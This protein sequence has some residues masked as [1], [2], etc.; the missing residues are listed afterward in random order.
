MTLDEQ[1]NQAPARARELRATAEAAFLTALQT[2]LAVVR[3]MCNLARHEDG[4]V[5]IHYM[6]EAQAA[7]EMA[8]ELAKRITLNE[9]LRYEIEGVRQDMDLISLA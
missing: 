1:A 6:K 8:L 4:E 5:R 7:F 3:T 9:G 2:E